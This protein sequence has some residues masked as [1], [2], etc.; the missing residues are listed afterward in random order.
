M[1]KTK[2][3][4]LRT[5]PLTAA[6]QATRALR[7]SRARRILRATPRTLTR[8]I[9]MDRFLGRQMVFRAQSI[10][11][12]RTRIVEGRNAHKF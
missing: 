3:L 1:M 6:S 4:I 12:I 2:P 7:T 11:W 9:W 8:E 5:L 10:G